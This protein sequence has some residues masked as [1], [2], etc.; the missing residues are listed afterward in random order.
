M[1]GCL[2]FGLGGTVT[3]P[4]ANLMDPAAWTIGPVIGGHNYSR[5]LPLHPGA[6]SGGLVL[7]IGALPASAHYVTVPFGSLAGKSRIAMRYTA[8]GAFT[9]TT[10]P[11][12]PA[13]ISL[14]FQRR[15]DDWSGEG[16]YE[17]YRW[18]ATFATQEI[19]P[20]EHEMIASL[21]G[22]WTAVMTSNAVDQAPAFA[23]ARDKA[24]LVGFVLGGGTGYG[25]G[26]SGPGR[27]T[28]TDFAVE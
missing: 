16:K 7:D 17:T 28:I 8:E 22:H 10:S 14:Y 3:K 19:A 15:G 2:L 20:G 24:E 26:A 13:L 6:S 5:D 11:G 21:D 27:L 9:A 25:H 23:A 18:F 4:P 1:S 12:A